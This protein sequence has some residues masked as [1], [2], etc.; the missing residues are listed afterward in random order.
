MPCALS[1]TRAIPDSPNLFRP[2]TARSRLVG[3]NSAGCGRTPRPLYPAR[4]GPD[5]PRRLRLPPARGADRAAPRPPAPLLAPPRRHPRHPRRL[6]RRP[7]ARLPRAR[8][9]PRLQ[10]H[11]RHPRPPDRHPPPPLRRRGA[12]RGH[13]DRRRPGRRLARPRPPRQA[14]G[15]RRPHRLRR[16]PLGRGPRQGRRRGPPRLRRRRPRPRAR[17]RCGGRDAAPPYIAARRAPDAAD[18]ADYQTVFATRPGAVAAP[19]ASLHFD[20]SLLAA[21]AAR[22]VAETRLTLHV[23]AGT[24]LPVKFEDIDGPPHARRMGRDRPRRRRR[25]QR[26]PRRRRPGDPGRHHRAP[27]P[28][29]RRHRPGP[30]RPLVRRDRHL[31]PPRLPLPHRATG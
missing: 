2:D 29:D 21:L 18:R 1:S 9:P 15:R 25:R 7:P 23:G 5:A 22:G 31:H 4:E 27:P 17:P 14:P 11:P 24:F 19:T 20:A 28:R 10:R 26:H 8:R 16:R 30:H 13:P 6:D 3:A 12:D